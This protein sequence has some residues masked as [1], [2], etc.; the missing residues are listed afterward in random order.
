MYLSSFLHHDR[1]CIAYLEMTARA[2]AEEEGFRVPFSILADSD[3]DCYDDSDS[4]SDDSEEDK[5]YSAVRCDSIYSGLL[6]ALERQA[7]QSLRHLHVNE[8]FLYLCGFYN[9]NINTNTGKG[10]KKS[11]E[12]GHFA[13]LQ[14][15]EDLECFTIDL[16]LIAHGRNGALSNKY[17]PVFSRLLQ[18]CLQRTVAGEM[19][20]KQV[21]CVEFV[22]TTLD[23]FE[24]IC[25]SLDVALQRTKCHD[26]SITTATTAMATVSITE[27]AV[28]SSS[29]SSSSIAVS[30]SIKGLK[31]CRVGV[32][33]R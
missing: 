1:L 13:A 11:S 28:S 4:D 32:L 14:F 9:T 19:I 2:L 10:Q 17:T 20:L 22:V 3:D 5:R 15:C 25:H 33:G 21:K 7:L 24:G 8:S 23:D 31:R 30:V 26:H 27:G 6:A 18:S 12:G 16:D 29:S